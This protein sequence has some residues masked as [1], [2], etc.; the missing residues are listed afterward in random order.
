VR[1]RIRNRGARDFRPK[2]GLL[3]PRYSPLPMRK[4]TAL[5]LTTLLAAL[6]V[7]VVFQLFVK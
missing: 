1:K 4:G 3:G 7:A 5:L 2:A 6:V